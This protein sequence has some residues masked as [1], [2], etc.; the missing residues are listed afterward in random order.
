M[1]ARGAAL[2]GGAAG[3]LVTAAA[4]AILIVAGA[5]DTEEQPAPRTAAPARTALLGKV[6][7]ST[8]ANVDEA[9]VFRTGAPWRILGVMSDARS[10]VAPELPTFKEAGY[11]IQA[12]SMRLT[13]RASRAI[14]RASAVLTTGP[15]RWRRRA[16]GSGG[17][18]GPP[19][20]GRG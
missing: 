11:D 18:P 13:R 10:P 9:V 2:L 12:G 16:R 8:M 5:F 20:R 4:A 19:P 14:R 15:V 3:A 1:T 17:G 6:I 7:E